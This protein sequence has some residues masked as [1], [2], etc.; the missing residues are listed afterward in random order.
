MET[1]N[2]LWRWE[3]AR[4]AFEGTVLKLIAHKR[5]CGKNFQNILYMEMRDCAV[6]NAIPHS[7]NVHIA[8]VSTIFNLSVTRGSI[9]Y[10]V[11]HCGCG[12]VWVDFWINSLIRLNFNDVI[13]YY[14]L[15]YEMRICKYFF[16][17]GSLLHIL[18][19]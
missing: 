17:I 18:F 16:I 5:E 4:C 15:A 2:K 19:I 13:T 7:A 12:C 9:Y 14:G 8:R 10:Q 6:Q 3:F 11:S 1:T